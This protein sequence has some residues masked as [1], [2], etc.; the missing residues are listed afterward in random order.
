MVTKNKVARITTIRGPWHN[1]TQL[2]YNSWARLHGFCGFCL[3][4][5]QKHHWPVIRQKTI[6]RY[7]AWPMPPPELPAATTDQF[8]TFFF[9]FLYRNLYIHTP[10]CSS[11]CNGS[12]VCFPGHLFA[13]EGFEGFHQRVQGGHHRHDRDVRWIHWTVETEPCG[14]LWHGVFYFNYSG[15]H[16]HCH[17]TCV[18]FSPI[19]DEMF[20]VSIEGTVG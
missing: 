4:V 1:Q 12:A 11:M 13:G 3:I 17:Q 5:W 20:F 14:D 9:F 10:F 19:P 16:A 18:V 8:Y 6:L 7:R 15:L 2:S